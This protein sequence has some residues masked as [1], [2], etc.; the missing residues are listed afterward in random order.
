MKPRGPLMIEHRLI[1]K[2]IALVGEQLP[3]IEER[4]E[5]DPVFIDTVVD[6]VR[7]YADR[8]HHGKEEE[9]LFRDLAGK[10]MSPRDRRMMEAL[11]EEHRYGRSVVAKLVQAKQDYLQGQE[12][13]LPRIVEQLRALVA[14]Y[15][16]HI[17]K[18]DKDFFP[19]SERYLSEP[20][21]QA[22]LQEFWEFDRQMIHEKYRAVVAALRAQ[23]Q[24]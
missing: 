15:P 23:L 7:T 5:V 2:M 19:N 24:P 17:E 16:Q 21:Q 8:T 13:A 14:F 10:A 22:M 18:E 20:E 4:H 11:V 6:F 3:L 12:D 1:E 9:I